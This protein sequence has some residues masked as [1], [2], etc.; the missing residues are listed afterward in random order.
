[1][2]ILSVQGKRRG[3]TIV[4]LIIVIT[5]I[6]ILA[7]ISIVAYNGVQKT[8]IDK[9]ILSDVDA[10][11]GEQT[12]YSLNHGGLAK[13][14]YSA[15]GANSDL[16][17]SGSPGNIIDVAVG[18]PEF[19]IRAYNPKGTNVT[20]KTATVRESNPGVCNVIKPSD[21]ASSADPIVNQAVVT[22]LAGSTNGYLDGTGTAALF[23]SPNAMTVG[24]GGD[25]YLASNNRIRKVTPSG[26]VTTFAGSG[27]AG[28]KDGAGINAE[29]N[30]I[31]AMESDASGNLYVAD[32]YRIRKVS[33][34]GEVGSFAGSNVSGYADGTTTTA[35]FS[36]I[37]GITVDAN[38]NIYVSDTGNFRIRKITPSGVVSTF[39]GSGIPGTASGTGTA[40]TVYNLKGMSITPSGDL[41]FVDGNSVRK[42][43]SAGVVT[44]I[45]GLATSSSTSPVNGNGAAVRFFFLM[46][47]TVDSQGVG[48]AAEYGSGCSCVRR[49]TPSGDVTTFAG[50]GTGTTDGT[51]NAA[52]FLYPQTIARDANGKMYVGDALGNRV[53]KIE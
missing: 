50:G 33:P 15:D 51:G 34:S 41:Y 49:I 45:A 19:C 12:R 52:R 28:F 8:A 16:N 5:I 26:V 25:L 13:A 2:N 22:T 7:A 27:V 35:R 18:G 29:F 6:G 1:M 14:W 23:S 43:T 38:G 17:F 4:E 20:F 40:A 10:L 44:P 11:A 47:I 31:T 21:A 48:Y 30:G 53:R 36:S 39:I 3:F 32:Q 37:G 9:S 46:D 42:A 24:V